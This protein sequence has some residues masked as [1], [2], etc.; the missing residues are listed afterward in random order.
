NA[1]MKIMPGAK[2][3]AT[4]SIEQKIPLKKEPVRVPFTV[5]GSL[6]IVPGNVIKFDPEKIKVAGIQVNSLMKIIGL[7]L[8]NFTKFKDSSGRIDL[9]GSSFLLKIEKFTDDAT[10]QGNMKDIKSG[11]KSLKVIF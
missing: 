1:S 9:V 4:G 10:I 2:I 5:E 7:E 8:S 11:N 6:K 3:L